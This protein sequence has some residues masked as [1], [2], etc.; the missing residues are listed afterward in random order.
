MHPLPAV[1]V[2]LLQREARLALNPAKIELG[3]G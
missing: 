1:R 3:E 2:V